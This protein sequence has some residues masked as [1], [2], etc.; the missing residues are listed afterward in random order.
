MDRDRA[1]FGRPLAAL[2]K[3][4]VLALVY[5]VLAGCT[6][7]DSPPPLVPPSPS[8]S[9][10]VND[11]ATGVARSSISWTSSSLVSATVRDA[12]GKVVPN[13]VVTFTSSS[14]TAIAFAPASTALTDA[15]G[16]A[17]VGVAPASAGTAGAYII[18][19]AVTVASQAVS[20][21]VSVSV[22]PAQVTPAALSLSV[23]DASSGQSRNALSTATSSLAKAVVTDASGKIV[24]NTVVTFTS[25]NPAAISYSP[26]STAVTDANGVASVAVAP[27]SKATA[28][29]YTLA[30]SAQVAGQTVSGTFNVTVT[31]TQSTLGGV[32]LFV[33]DAAS[34]LTK[35]SISATAP[36]LAKALVTDTAGKPVANAVVNFTASSGTAVIFSPASTAMT[37][38]NGLAS[39]S[40]APASYSTTGA[41]TLT[42]TAQAAGQSVL[43]SYNV[44]IAALPVTLGLFSP[45][46]GSLSA[47]GTVVLT[48][49][50]LGLPATTP[51]SVQFTSVCASQSPAKATLT[52]VVISSGGAASATYVD[53]GCGTR[54]QVTAS[55]VGTTVSSSTYLNVDSVKA[56]SIQ[57]VSA[58]PRV[59]AL[60]GTGG[61]QGSGSGVTFPEVSTIRFQVLDQGG[62]PL[63]T[64][65]AVTLS[66]SND[67]G[68]ILIDGVAGPVI[69]QTDAQ[70][71]VQV[72][73]Q[74]GT[75]PTPL[76]VIAS[77]GAGSIQRVTNSVQLAVSTGQP[78]QSR[79]SFSASALNLEAWSYDGATSDLSIIAADA[80]GNPVPDGT[81]IS[82]ITDAGSVDAN[83]QTGVASTRPL[84]GPGTAG[85]CSVQ[86][87]SQGVRPSN[88][89][90]RVAAYAVG[91]E[92]YVDGNS[93]NRYDAGETFYDQGYLFLD[94]NENG[95][96]DAGERVVPYLSSQSAACGA[97]PLTP[98]APST[99]DGVWGRAHVRQQATFVFS[100][101]TGYLRTGPDFSTPN[102]SN[103]PNTYVLDPVSC[104]A[105]F[106]FWLQDLNG[107]PMP[108]GT[109]VKLDLAAAAGVSAAPSEV[110]KVRSTNAIGGTQHTYAFSGVDKTTGLC[111]GKGPVLVQIATPNGNTTNFWVTVTR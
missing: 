42:A 109:T 77:I 88:G 16:V 47:Y 90:L 4:A 53:K 24:A 65:A 70:G 48:V 108:Y 63:V 61:T 87:V 98:S 101:S 72:Q 7:G 58:S 102:T 17:S 23:A 19:A 49:P 103:V 22:T 46:Q 79:F 64:P 27:A 34:G 33:V 82:F 86:L 9:V 68:G 1:L 11:A 45:D 39:V 30:A 85:T 8:V 44:A 50:V 18:T 31:A 54:D 107:N 95:T 12:S 92:H 26:A 91:E 66:L 35:T 83:C 99:C 20:G 56:T 105:N 3:G 93:N 36:S 37:D 81:P 73:V 100:G 6:A 59:I 10:V 43:G 62:L 28:G 76:W 21:S 97:N 104:T 14:T 89:R 52:P 57:F 111:V 94:R 38:S 2:L 32:T 15:N 80:M 55:I 69:K 13:A 51:V 110:Q 78:I 25:S 60:R 84:A 75:I 71:Y 74:S 40:V 67:T 29:A 96:F 41:Y 5:A 106:N